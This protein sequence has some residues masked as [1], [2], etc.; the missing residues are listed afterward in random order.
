MELVVG[1]VSQI[2]RYVFSS[3][4]LRENVG[5]SYLV[6]QAAD[7]WALEAV[8]ET[9]RHNNNIVQKFKIT[10]TFT[11]WTTANRLKATAAWKPRSFIPVG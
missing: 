7:N 1:K 10:K 5:A 6:L 8:I 4:R 11:S 3:N 2:Q 9:T